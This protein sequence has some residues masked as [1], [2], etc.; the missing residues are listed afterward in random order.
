ML[1]IHAIQDA[2]FIYPLAQDANAQVPLAVGLLVRHY[3]ELSDAEHVFLY[4]GD[5]CPKG[6][7]G[8]LGEPQSIKD[9]ASVAQPQRRSI[10]HTKESPRP[11][12]S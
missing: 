4:A 1:L 8:R 11:S 7:P 2:A 5:S 6:I 12:R 10:L 3:S 9:D